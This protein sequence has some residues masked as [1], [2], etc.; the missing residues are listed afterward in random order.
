MTQ[1]VGGPESPEQLVSRH[2]RYL[3]SGPP[4]GVFAV[5][6]GPDA[7]SAGWVGYWESDWQGDRVWE[8]GWHILPEFQRRGVATAAAQLALGRAAAEGLHAFAHAFPA[9]ANAASNGVCRAAGFELM[10]EVDVEY[11]PGKMMRSY[12]WRIALACESH[13]PECGAPVPAPG[14]CRDHFHA[15]LALEA[16]VPGGPGELAH[17]YAVATYGLQHPDSMGF[18]VASTEGMRESVRLA[19]SGSD[20]IGFLRRRARGLAAGQGSRITRRADDPVPCWRVDSWPM[21]VCDVLAGG[22]VA[23]AASVA[24]WAG[25]VLEATEGLRPTA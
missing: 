20:D 9:V 24:R 2:E 6:V 8:I 13:C 14:S 1:H 25:S 23:Y 4:G 11:P 18:T 10:G 5:T 15:L 16:T 12:D 7:S 21:T 19:L 17:F 22:A 3:A